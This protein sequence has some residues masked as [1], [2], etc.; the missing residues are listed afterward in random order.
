MNPVTP[1]ATGSASRSDAGPA[2]EVASEVAGVVT[3]PGP[4]SRS[5]ALA[6]GGELLT[7]VSLTVNGKPAHADVA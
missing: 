2:S 6:D 4:D 1:T 7:P 5:A 3:A